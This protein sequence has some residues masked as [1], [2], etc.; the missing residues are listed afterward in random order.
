MG[1]RGWHKTSEYHHVGEGRLKNRHMIFEHSH[2]SFKILNHFEKFYIHKRS[3][4]RV[5]MASIKG[6]NVRNKMF[7]AI[8]AMIFIKI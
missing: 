1:G 4:F 6:Q 8:L 3:V 2:M 5:D 7:Y